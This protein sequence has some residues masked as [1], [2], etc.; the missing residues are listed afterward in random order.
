MQR[1]FDIC[2]VSAALTGGAILWSLRRRNRAAGLAGS[3]VLVALAGGV[4]WSNVLAYHDA[5]LAPRAR[6]AELQHIGGLVAG[7]GPTFVNDYEIYAVR[8]FLRAGYP[9][10]PAEYRPVSLLLRDGTS[11][12]KSAY[13]DLDSFPTATLEGYRSIVVPRAPIESRPPSIYQL[14][15]QGRYY[16]LWQRPAQPA[17]EII[18][19]VPYGDSNT[20]PYCG[21]AESGSS[22]PEC[23]IAPVSIPRCSQVLRLARFA[24]SQHAELVAYQRPEPIVVRGD[25]MVWPESWFHEPAGGNLTA[26]TPGTGVAHI[27]VNSAQRYELWLGGGFSRGFEVSVDG[28]RVGR[29]KDQLANV[30]DYTPVAD[31]F[32]EPGIHTF[33]LR[34]PPSDLTPGSGDTTFTTLTAIALQ[35]LESPPSE[36]FTVAPAQ[37]RTLCGR[38]LDWIEIV[39]APA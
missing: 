7:K 11:L 29:V 28:R 8:H 32:L 36:I 39:A 16:Q 5:L 24:Q 26:T 22:R 25:Q 14:E 9:V 21:S 2:R 18:E 33:A 12:T 6:L 17:R 3:L 31:V 30:G 20:H 15:W 1:R 27:A 23:S 37:A 38:P 4:L 19:H 13:A 34:Y 10:A 35:P